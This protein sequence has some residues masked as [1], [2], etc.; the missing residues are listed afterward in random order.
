MTVTSFY[1]QSR[2]YTAAQDRK[3]HALLWAGPDGVR[4]EAGSPLL[5][6]AQSTPAMSVRVNT[7]WAKRSNYLAQSDAVE[8]VTVPAANAS[9]PRIDLIVMR[10]RDTESGDSE[11]SAKV[12]LVQGTPAAVPQTPSLT[13]MV[14]VVLA[15]VYVAAGTTTIAGSAITDRRVL[16][17]QYGRAAWQYSRSAN[18]SIANGQLVDVALTTKEVDTDGWGLSG[19]G[20]VVPVNGLYLVSGRNGW[21]AGGSSRGG[22]I[23]L[24]G[25]EITPTHYRSPTSSNALSMAVP[26]G[27]AL[28][29][30]SVGQSLRLQA[31]QDTGGALNLSNASMTVLLW[32]RT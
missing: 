10:W 31:Y 11:S 32:Q 19:G 9:N 21:V 8:N 29:A 20:L 16:A 7:G 27:S 18:Q 23:T 5:V 3:L 30:A 2:T 12:E 22:R 13:N 26:T 24:D 4:L 14:V 28:V 17:D 6:Q 15:E 25:N 1:Q